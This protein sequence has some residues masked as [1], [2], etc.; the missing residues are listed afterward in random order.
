MKNTKETRLLLLTPFILILSL[1]LPAQEIA[2]EPK[3]IIKLR[4]FN[5]NNSVQ[6]LLLENQLKTGSK[7]EPVAG[8][9]FQLYLDNASDSSLAGVMKTDKTGKAK[10]FL[11]ETLKDVWND[12]SVHRFIAIVP[13]KED[14]PVELVIAKAR[15][16]VDTLFEEG[17]RQVEAS[18]QKFENGKWQP[19]E[20]VE[21][22]IGVNRLGGGILSINEESGFTTDSTGVVKAEFKRA[23]LPGDQAG[24]IIL[25]V[26]V[27]DN[28]IYGNLKVEKTVPWGKKLTADNSFFERRSLWSTR[29]NTPLW[30]LIMAGSI[31]IGVWGTIGY[32]VWQIVRIKRLGGKSANDSINM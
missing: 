24:N 26:K 1:Q 18:V 29:F 19:A 30:L 4:Y 3:E 28:D 5:D 21:M 32:L 17:S 15:I 14:E 27:D 16:S 11:P 6:Y 23:D 12:T 31:V 20:G 10:A 8:K 13:G 7:I 25:I 22:R 2:A 9:I